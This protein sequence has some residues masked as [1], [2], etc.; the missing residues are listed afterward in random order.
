MTLKEFMKNA[1]DQEKCL[2]CPR[3][4]SQTAKGLSAIHAA[5]IIHR[6]L[7][8]DNIYATKSGDRN[9]FIWKI[10]DFGL[11]IKLEHSL[12]YELGDWDLIKM[13]A[14]SSTKEEEF[15]SQSF[16][17]TSLTKA[18]RCMSRC[19]TLQKPIFTP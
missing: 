16:K 8:P 9:L 17:G 7:K 6:D 5:G 19:P 1:S 2:E 13:D 15:S 3:I 10:G 18:Q 4:I 11:S 12:A 14:I